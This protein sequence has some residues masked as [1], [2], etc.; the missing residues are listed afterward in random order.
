MTSS[1]SPFWRRW[2]QAAKAPSTTPT[3]SAV[4]AVI[5]SSMRPLALEQRFMFDGAGASDAVHAAADAHAGAMAMLVSQSVE[6]P[7]TVVNS[8]TLSNDTGTSNSDFVTNIASQTI[9]GSLSSAL[10]T[11]EK[12]E[13][14]YDSG[15]TWSDASYTVGSSSWSTTTT[16]SGSNTFE[17]RVTNAYASS[18]AYT[19]SYTLDTTT[20]TTTISSIQFSNDR[21]SSSSDFITNNASQTISAT[22]SSTPGTGDKLF[23][24]LDNGATWTDISAKVSGTTLSWDGLILSGS[25][26]LK[27]KVTDVAGNDGTVTSQSYTIDTMAPSAPS[28]PTL[29]AAS[30]TGDSSSDRITRVTTPRVT[31]TAESGS[32]VTLY[33]TDGVTVLG[34]A[35]ATGGNWEITTAIPL[36]EGGHSLSVIATDTAG[37]RSATPAKLDI[38]IDTTA[39]HAIA[40]STNS[41]A[42]S[43]ATAGATI[44]TLSASE[45]GSITYELSVGD[46]TNDADNGLFKIDGNTLKVNGVALSAGA[47]HIYLKAVDTAGNESY[48]ATT[49]TVQEAPTVSSIVRAGGASDSVSGF[50]TQVAYTVTFSEA[51]IGVD[52]SDFTLSRTGSANGTIASV[53]GSGTTYTVT[54]SG[55]TGDGSLRLDLN[56]SGTGIQTGSNIAIAGGYTT[57][58]TFALDHTAPAMPSMLTLSP[59]SDT[60]VTNITTPTFTG[61]AEAGSTVTLYDTDGVT[62]LGSTTA[63]TGDTWSLTIASPLSA[64]VHS[65]TVRATDAAGNQSASSDVLVVTIDQVAPILSIT[66]N[67][68]D[69]NGMAPAQITFT[70]SEPPVEFTADDITVTGGTLKDLSVT[71]NPLVYTASLTATSGITSGIASI[72]VSS[73]SYADAA[74]N[75]GAAA[76]LHLAVDTVAPVATAN[77]V[78]FSQDSGSSGDLITNVAQQTISGTLSAPLASGETVHILLDNGANWTPAQATAGATSWSV[79]QILSSGS[80][81]LL[82][83]VSDAA[84]NYLT[85]FSTVYQLDSAVPVAS[86][87]AMQANSITPMLTGTSSL[88]TGDSMTVTVGGATYQ[89]VP[90][91][92]TWTLDLATA[93]PTS[94]TLRLALDQQ[95][96]VMVSTQ[97]IAGNQ[98]TSY[99]TLTLAPVNQPVSPPPSESVAPPHTPHTAWAP[100]LPD[101]LTASRESSA[102]A[103]PQQIPDFMSASDSAWGALPGQT[104]INS[105]VHFVSA[106]TALADTERE[107]MSGE[108][109]GHFY[110]GVQPLLGGDRL[111]G[112][113]PIPDAAS[114]AGQRITVQLGSD[115]FARSDANSTLTL[116]STLA[117]DAPLPDWLRFD[118]RTGRFEGTPPPGFEGSLSIK[119]IV[120]D[121]QGNMAVQVFKLVVSKDGRPTAM[122]PSDAMAPTGRASLSE[123]IHSARSDAAARLAVLS[124]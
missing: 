83:K 47:Y 60:G 13:V 15:T 99:G 105:L 57:G 53:T 124:S 42:M 41:V 7:T 70:F 92:G 86:F 81:T 22:L 1:H 50:A 109:G 11:G 69:I 119:V 18:T 26:T 59:V 120:R 56:S 100:A 123:K 40:L 116:S 3:H 6:A 84:G 44:A 68:S 114:I 8:A 25:N 46:A 64:G 111:V 121:S 98:G 5:G 118:A 49:V 108:A 16:L 35:I 9:S 85:P 30:D 24:S 28:T 65:L 63:A 61:T 80:H 78:L 93:V 66:S 102:P 19:H 33:G 4:Q 67:V 94:G 29:A 97:D 17:A 87:N 115:A 32:T 20:P 48:L 38:T 37:N 10:E 79:S 73:G 43:N 23:G 72:A 122:L 36:V 104:A 52:A 106:M 58:Q 39:P 91:A 82:V 74:G 31:G 71:S 62:V 12:V 2:V 95:Y 110:I 103:L 107:R 89:V 112:Q 27:L 51:V 55:I 76:A 45:S 101:V 77:G 96:S 34:S 90:S 113:R 88:V 75:S 21:G 117:D 14:S 54:V